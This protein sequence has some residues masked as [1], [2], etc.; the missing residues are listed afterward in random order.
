MYSSILIGD[1][2]FALA[3]ADRK[4][5][6]YPVDYVKSKKLKTT[7]V[8]EEINLAESSD[9]EPATMPP[10]RPNVPDESSSD[11]EPATKPPPRHNSPDENTVPNSPVATQTIDEQTA[12][13]LF[14]F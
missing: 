2:S 7:F 11:D 12:K 5:T 3:M 10:P 1:K 6:H 8:T 4:R 13:R 9:D 14:S